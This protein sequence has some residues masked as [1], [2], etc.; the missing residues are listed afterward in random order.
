MS[1]IKFSRRDAVGAGV[2][3][4]TL[5]LLQREKARAE[6]ASPHFFLQ[7][8]VQPGA[9][10]MY[11]FDSRPFAFTAAGKMANFAAT[12]PVAWD[13]VAGGH[14]LA[15]TYAMAM[16]PYKDRFTI[17]N[18]V[19]MPAGFDGHE[20]NV[21]SLVSANP[22][23]GNYFGPTTS[24]GGQPVDYLNIGT[25]NPGVNITNRDLSLAMGSEVAASLASNAALLGSADPAMLSRIIAR[26]QACAGGVGQVS[27]GCDLMVRGL[28]NS[29]NLAMR[30]AKTKAEFVGGDGP[31]TKATKV[32]LT[33]FAQGVTDVA[34]L[35]DA[36]V[37]FD[38]H[39]AAHAKTPEAIFPSFFTDL[40]AVFA[41]LTTTPY[42]GAAGLS[43]L[44]VTTVMISAEFTRTHGQSGKPVTDTGTDHNPLANS[45]L[46][47]GKGIKTD[48]VIG[49]SDLDVLGPDGNFAAASAAPLSVDAN[50]LKRA[51]KPYDFDAG[52]IS[53]SLPSEYH[54]N[55]YIS[56]ASVINTVL[57]AFGVP[58]AKWMT[59]DTA[60]QGGV[61]VPAKIV[62]RA[63]A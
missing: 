45:I 37:D 33:Y 62:K 42:D 36:S 58:T 2:G 14:C 48:Q 63:R 57:D 51:G 19:H 1:R 56:M 46:L 25:F 18:G 54:L 16:K 47:A 8:I 40:A 13:G 50:L 4:A 15:S 23:G 20:Q 22:F 3:L 49:A 35:T 43:M 5:G 6:G 28:N 7:I 61:K 32:A 30:L 12:A 24:A 26:A 21:N 55:D 34:L 39:D 60:Q 9:D 17:I 41:A 29:T 53:A 11:M 10:S 59:N 52:E 31:L 44:D 38:T 27:G